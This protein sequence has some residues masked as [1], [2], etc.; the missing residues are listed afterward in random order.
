MAT[1]N[2]ISLYIARD[3]D[4]TDVVGVALYGVSDFGANVYTTPPIS[5]HRTFLGQTT[6]IAYNSI[7]HIIDGPEWITFTFAS[8][9]S[10]LG[11]GFYGIALFVSSGTAYEA[12]GILWYGA[13]DWSDASGGSPYAGKER[14]FVDANTN[15]GSGNTRAYDMSV[16]GFT[17]NSA[18]AYTGTYYQA[19]DASCQGVLTYLINGLTKPITPS[20]ANG[21]GPGI[22]FSNWTFG[23]VN[24]GG[25]TSYRL[26]AGTTSGGLNLVTTT[27]STSYQ[28]PVGNI[29]RTSLLGGVIY[30][31][32]DA[33]DGSS[34]VTG[35]TWSFDPRPAKPTTPSPTNAAS[36]Q[37]LNVA[38]LGWAAGSANTVSYDVYFTGSLAPY[39]VAQT[40][41]TFP[42]PG[43]PLNYD[44][45]YSWRIDA[46][47]AWGTTTGDVWSFDTLSF[48]PPTTSWVNLPGKTLGPM[49]S[50]TPGVVGADFRWLGDNNMIT[51]RRFVAV[52][53]NRFWYED[54]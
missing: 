53:R 27:A 34:W 23:W 15:V 35:D 11:T 3:H 42:T 51:V 2:S 40:G 45:A 44:T 46:T 39:S 43:S 28:I 10:L 54:L 37:R 49:S 14:A 8:P 4:S 50:P 32:V 52:A 24:G 9:V 22:D 19:L 47:N 25:A 21:S 12:A 20:P 31:R 29:F 30:W 1:I 18:T 7:P 36:D 16:T 26:F 13:S 41:L 38:N 6:S 17:K 5:T 48:D 33:T